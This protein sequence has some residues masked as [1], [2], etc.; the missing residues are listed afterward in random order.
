MKHIAAFSLLSLLAAG[1]AE[2]QLMAAWSKY[3]TVT[4]NTTATGGGANVTEAQT[5]YPV[6]VR[7]SSQSLA[8]GANALSEAKAGGADIRFTNAAGDTVLAHEIERWTA[9]GADIWVKVPAVAGNGNTAIRMYWGNAAANTTSSGPAVFD[10]TQG[11]TAVWHMNGAGAGGLVDEND[12]TGGGLTAAQFNNSGTNAAS[13]DENGIG[14]YRNL[15][16]D[17]SSGQ[18]F[19]TSN[20]ARANFLSTMSYT[21]SA[22]V[23]PTSVE[24][25]PYPTI[26]SKHDNQWTLRA[27]TNQ[28]GPWLFFH[29]DGG[30]WPEAQSSEMAV[31]GQWA[32]VVGVRSQTPNAMSIYVNG[33]QTG[34]TNN[35]ASGGTQPTTTPVA[36]GRMA[37]NA[38]RFWNG[39]IAE[40]RLEN[41][42]RS[43]AR[44][45]LD[46]ETQKPGA[47]A[48]T[49]GATQSVA[50]R[51]LFYPLKNP[52]YVRNVAIENN[53]PVVTG[54]A[55]GFSIS[56]G[57]P[58]A[59]LPAGLS[60][61]TTTGV[62]S[63][64]PTTLTAA[65]QLIVTVNLQGGGTGTDTLNIAVVAGNP[66]GAPTAVVA[67]PGNGQAT[68][69]WTAPT[70]TGSGPIT[71]YTVRASQ[72]TTK[73]CTWTTGALSC[74]VTGLTNG[75]SYTFTVRATN[76]AGTGAASAVSNAVFPAGVPTAPGG[77]TA[78][79]TSG[80]GT[81]PSVKIDWTAPSNNGG[82]T[83]T[84]FTATSNPAGGTCTVFGAGATTCTISTGLSY[85]TAYTFTVTATNSAGASPASAASTVLTPTGLLPG[86][87]ALLSNGAA[88][89]FAFVLTPEAL[90]SDKAF[91]LSILDLR[92]RTIWARTAHPAKDGTRMLEWN[93][94]TAAGQAASAGLYMVRVTTPDGVASNFV[95]MTLAP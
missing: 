55:T 17:G 65:Q 58:G 54:T 81:S 50:A 9:T 6:L 11:F 40:V 60:F 48:L 80:G 64:T 77:V 20:A 1:Q 12:A 30:S 19:V 15:V 71:G 90:A 42:A 39:A 33:V 89:P 82:A 10:T 3:R 52:S 76:G 4:V 57:T 88:R 36:I 53:V 24:H 23:K 74:A 85:G 47:T 86:S 61:N 18:G 25:T 21:V 43:A 91:T 32:H 72:D 66:P 14:Y 22:W 51:A 45:K 31:P 34:N 69:S 38:D 62:I 63:G 29:G 83:I 7:L 16:S 27:N 73:S 87:F 13:S 78:V 68:V 49:M 46:Y 92:G 93:G 94:R 2:A 75:T 41:V 84:S 28:A 70:S 26:V 59:Q 5:N 37:E 67:T 95:R 79:Q 8:T 35:P 44:I 56:S